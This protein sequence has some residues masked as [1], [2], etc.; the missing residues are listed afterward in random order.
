MRLALWAAGL[1]AVFV[2]WFGWQSWQDG[3]QA[4]LREMRTVLEISATSI[5]RYLKE[6]EAGLSALA[7]DL[8]AEGGMDDLARVQRMLRRFHD[9]HAEAASITLSRRADGVLLA[10]STTERLQDLPANKGRGGPIF[11]AS[12]DD[13]KLAGR[14]ILGRPLF[15]S[16]V[17]RWVFPLAT[18]IY[19]RDGRIVAVLAM[20]MPVDFVQAVW[21]AAPLSE[22][23]TMG[24]IR[25]DGLLVSRW[26]LPPNARY[27]EIYG[28]KRSGALQQNL[29]SAGFPD[30]GQVEGW[31]DVAQTTLRNVY[32]RLP[33][34]GV[35]AFVALPTSEL[36]TAWW[37]RVRVPYALS[38][39]LAVGAFLGA[40]AVLR[41]QAGMEADRRAAAVAESA[42]QAKSEFIARMSHELRTPLNAVL[43]LAELMTLDRS[44]ERTQQ[45]LHHLS[46]A[47]QHLLTLINDL[48]DLSQI[49]A[50][51]VRIAHTDFRLRELFEGV[52]HE[53]APIAAK[54]GLA[55]V[56]DADF[57]AA[58]R[59]RSDRTRIRQI[60]FNLLSNAIKYGG[61]RGE[62]RIE[63]R[64]TPGRLAFAVID[65]GPGMTPA[66][67]DAIFEP[68]NRLGRD[69]GTV[70]TGIGLTITRTLVECMDGKLSV[71]SQVGA[72]RRFGVEL[73]LLAPA[74]GPE[75]E[76]QDAPAAS[77][78]A[79]TSRQPL[80]V[81]YADDDE[82]NR[83]IVAG[84]LDLVANVALETADSGAACLRAAR[85]R[86]V[87]LMLV[88]MRMPGM[89]G[90]DVIRAVRADA[91]MRGTPCIAISA[92]AM[93]EDIRAAR[94]A[95][96]DGYVTKPISSLTLY[97]E[98]R[99]VVVERAA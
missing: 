13:S 94:E 91:A 3:R 66:Q 39:L 86:P 69:D 21:Q 80:R 16:L 10:S 2:T 56:L 7:Y 87:D 27:E 19:G 77:L 6:V 35:T 9:A 28:V 58:L 81:L 97:S 42:S 1:L 98:M 93:P 83:I 96:F 70:G 33:H 12:Q 44:A 63:A 41:R 48:L 73:P 24:L 74:A 49:E 26:K 68:F 60:L 89:D 43:G 76:A 17:Q 78:Q 55:L 65:P 57:D 14:L 54:Q 62:V 31:S 64:A 45:R 4:Q 25:D 50:G 90:L 72:G 67:L 5:D 53:M 92:N 85:E 29:I 88:D 79:L 59:V 30:S 75:A 51:V 34:F 15:G 61:A 47:G 38:L 36:A 8:Q 40:R 82:V 32:R 37:Q 22:S 52:A 84:Y 95:G 71:S 18:M 99:R 23:M 20:A 46:E 11:P